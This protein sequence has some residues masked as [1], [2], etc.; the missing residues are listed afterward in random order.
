MPWGS[1][2]VQGGG[3]DAAPT[4]GW[5]NMTKVA[6]IHGPASIEYF[7]QA[8][9][10]LWLIDQYKEM[11]GKQISRRN[12][13]ENGE[14]SP[15]KIRPIRNATDC[16]GLKTGRRASGCINGRTPVPGFG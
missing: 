3:E 1:T 12:Q 7:A 16:V 10:Y 14:Y 6:E 8:L 2:I 15:L 5:L 13:R 11:I 4:P 9:T